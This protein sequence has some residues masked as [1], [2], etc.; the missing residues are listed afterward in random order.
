MTYGMSE[1]LQGTSDSRLAGASN[2][3]QAPTLSTNMQERWGTS[4]EGEDGKARTDQPGPISLRSMMERYSRHQREKEIR[5]TM[6]TLKMIDHDGAMWAC[7]LIVSQNST[8]SLWYAQKH[9]KQELPKG[10]EMYTFRM[11]SIGNISAVVGSLTWPGSRPTFA[12][13]SNSRSRPYT[14]PFGNTTG[15]FST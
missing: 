14:L 15:S 7:L 2:F 4:R 13:I 11:T 8:P 1:I 12:L 3:K 9:S 6:M 5:T 10:H